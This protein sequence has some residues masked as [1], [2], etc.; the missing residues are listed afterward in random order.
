M[1]ILWNVIKN[2]LCQ[3]ALETDE[4]IFLVPT[5]MNL[6]AN[7]R[8][9]PLHSNILSRIKRI[10]AALDGSN[11]LKLTSFDLTDHDKPV[12]GETNITSHFA[13]LE[14]ECFYD[15]MRKAV[16]IYS[17]TI[18]N[19]S[20][21]LRIWVNTY[22]ADITGDM[23]SSTDMS[24]DPSTT[25]HGVP[26]AL[27]KVISDGVIIAWKGSLEKPIP[28]SD[29]EI[30]HERHVQNAFQT[31]KKASYDTEVVGQIPYNDGSQY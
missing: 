8:E 15:L 23:T 5:Y 30:L 13:N 1:L 14:S 10:E 26:K 2:D 9:Y 11:Y 17:G 28:L 4:D 16:W 3:Q 6:V 18:T 7:Q 24:V 29:H 27:H 31:L 19:V 12:T 25:T 20:D 22:P 21:G